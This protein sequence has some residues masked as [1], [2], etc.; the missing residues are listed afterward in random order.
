MPDFRTLGSADP[1]GVGLASRAGVP[2]QGT[3]LLREPISPELVLVD[4]ELARRARTLL[5][6]PVP[7]RVTHNLPNQ[8]DHPGDGATIPTSEPSPPAL[9]DA[10]DDDD[11]SERRW[12]RLAAV[13]TVCVLLMG[14]I[15]AIV[16]K[17]IGSERRGIS[18]APLTAQA[19]MT[20]AR[21]LKEKPRPQAPAAAPQGDVADAL[22]PVRPGLVLQFV[23]HRFGA[24]PVHAAT[25]QRCELTWPA[26]GLRL[27]LVARRRACAEGK[28]VGVAM[29]RRP[30]A[31]RAGLRIGD[32]VSRLRRLY[33]LAIRRH[34]QWWRLYK[35]GSQTPVGGLFAHVSQRRVDEFWVG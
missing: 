21:L 1:L 5:P 15:T 22:M 29:W 31:T 7:A 24:A 10:H 32:R 25:G 11:A 28:L 35:G 34:N 17:S 6:G 26:A 19:Q 8:A 14:A 33:P 16:I 20:A 3:A 18:P 30:W 23:I 12:L 13:T 2:S 27:T 9:A 4:P